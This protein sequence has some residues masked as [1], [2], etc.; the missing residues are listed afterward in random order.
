MLPKNQ[1]IIIGAGGHGKVVLSTALA[2]NKTVL[3]F[4]DNDQTIHHTELNDYPV[5]GDI[6]FIHRNQHAY[7]VLAIGHNATRKNIAIQLSPDLKSPALIHPAAYVHPSA[8]IGCGTVVF[9]GAVIQP[10]VIIGEHCIINTGTTVDHDCVIGNFVHLAPGVH[11]AGNIIVKEGAFLGIGSVVIPNTLIG[12]WA[13]VGAGS[14]VI[15]PVPPDLTV[16][17][18][19][20]KEF[21]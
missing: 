10:D 4:I 14:V 17:G 16:M 21:A 2:C 15:K 9:A 8:Q 5:L 12:A 1:L 6:D 18:V 13:I 20:A 19:P 7:A 11:L 3:G